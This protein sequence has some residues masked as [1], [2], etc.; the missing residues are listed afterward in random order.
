MLNPQEFEARVG[1]LQPRS[2]AWSPVF[3]GEGGARFCVLAVGTKSG[4][5]W[6]WRYR[7]PR[8][9]PDPQRNSEFSNL[10]LV[11]QSQLQTVHE[12]FGLS[13]DYRR[14]TTLFVPILPAQGVAG[15]QRNSEISNLALVREGSFSH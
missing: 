3:A 4:R 11:R 13:G 14:N 2:V 10:A 8:V 7:L 1:L 12:F 6:L 15:P 5:V 9:S